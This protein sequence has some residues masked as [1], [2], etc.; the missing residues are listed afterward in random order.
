MRATRYAVAV[1]SAALVLAASAPAHAAVAA[2]V[3]GSFAAGFAT[4]VVVAAQGEGITFVNADP[5]PHNFVA[6]GVYLS[7][8]E[9]KK[10]RWCTSF[11]AKSCPLFWSP[12][13]AAGETTEVE[14]LERLETGQQYPFFCSLHPGMKGTLVVR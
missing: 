7:K 5:A 14:G 13:V 2:A 11:S 4:P 6:D 9:A 12:T 10:A 1:A 8:K 3:P